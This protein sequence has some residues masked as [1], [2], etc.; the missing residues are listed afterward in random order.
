M[1]QPQALCNYFLL[2]LSMQSVAIPVSGRLRKQPE[3]PEAALPRD[4]QPAG[5]QP[6]VRV[7]RVRRRGGVHARQCSANP[8]RGQQAPRARP[9][10]DARRA[11]HEGHGRCGVAD[12]VLKA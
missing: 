10:R 7:Q 4:L 6:L 2:V 3:G 8:G 12:L 9:A 5:A 11:P 1:L